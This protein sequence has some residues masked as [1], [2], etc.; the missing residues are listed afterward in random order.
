MDLADWDYDLPPERIARRPEAVREQ[1]RLMVL[2]RAGGAPE[3]RRFADLPDLLEPGDQIVANDT[4]VMAARLF[5]RRPTGGHVQIL[6]LSPG[7]G[8][9][10]AL[11]RPGRRLPIGEVI[12]LDGGGTATIVA[13]HDDGEITV[14]LDAPPAEVMARQGAMPL[15]P[16]LHRPADA[17]DVTRYQTVYAGPLGAAAAPTAGLHFS[18]A[19]FARLRER[20]VGFATVTL[21]VG[22]GTFRPLRD[23]DVAAGHLHVEPYAVG[24]DAVAAIAGA[25]ARGS[26]V[27]AVG[28]TTAR[29]L[30]AA[31]PPGARVPVAG[32]GETDLFVR[33]PYE[34][35]SVDALIT[36]FHLPQSSLLMLVAAFV[37]RE[38]L[39]AA[40]AEAVR[41]E[42]RFYS[43]GDAMLVI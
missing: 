26:R 40:Y 4:K 11:A 39:L 34:F 16:Y 23:E 29:T 8:P 3:H 17:D 10:R 41:E 1:S 2:R 25:R 15:P 30:E 32:A 13:R 9:V 24:P 37:G 5:G 33:P 12:R 36:N 38:R 31:T 7:P 19:V 21:H 20:D 27:V 22:I 18:E 35:R 43:Y 28:T 14:D 42:Y 6:L